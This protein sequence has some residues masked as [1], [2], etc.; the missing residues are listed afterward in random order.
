MKR[1]ETEDKYKWKLEDIFESEEDWEKAYRKTSERLT[2]YRFF[3]N[4]TISSAENLHKCLALDEE[5]SLS[6]EQL[7]VY[8]AMRRDQDTSNT[9]YQSLIGRAESLSV[10]VSSA[11]SFIVP[12][13]LSL[14]M[15]DFDKYCNEVAELSHYKMMF[16][17]IIK[18]AP[19]ILTSEQEEILSQMGAIASA[20]SGIFNM[21][22]N[23]DLKFPKIADENGELVELTKS[24][25]AEF[26]ES[27]NRNSRE[28]AYKTLYS[29]YAKQRNTIAATLYANIK[30]NVFYAKVRKHPSALEK[31][32]FADNV[33]LEVY[34][35]LIKTVKKNLDPMDKYLEL[36]QDMLGLKNLHAYD[37]S[38]PLVPESNVKITYEEA[39]ET[40]KRGL[41]ILG[42]DYV[43]KLEEAR[44]EGWIDVYENEGKRG[45]A[46]SW[47]AYGSHPYV[48]LNHKDNL[49]SMFTLAHEMG[50]AMHS[51][52]SD[53][54]N[55][56]L[57]AG[58]TIFVAEVASTVNEVLL[59]N[60]LLKESKD[61][62]TKKYLLNYFLEQFRGTIYRQTMFAEFEMITHAAVENGE[63]LTVD[64]F[65]EIY[66]GLSKEYY[67]DML[68][69]D[70][71]VKTEWLR[72]PHFYNA[73]YVYKYATGF[74]AAISIA[75]SILEEGDP[76]V[77]R[78]L[79]FLKSG[80]TDYPIELL[81]I[82]GVDMSTAK[83]IE[84]ALQYFTDLVDELSD[85]HKS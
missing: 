37:I 80:G 77:E 6:I 76:A 13:L 35:N 53:E 39:Y 47:G 38:T 74:S 81:K 57:Y 5:I 61:N 59:M 60:H 62:E 8:A 56:Y 69:Q 55:P 12:E 20:P 16:E 46:Y 66:G 65:D 82:A 14:S 33:P 79:R 41:S 18:N 43:R 3:E 28:N 32:L 7:Y 22:N 58:Y 36:K 34:K 63:T 83:P 42:N 24:N 4:N 51:Y 23:A 73:F 67:G 17:E 1:D 10:E 45:G 26:M 85:I 50:H 70:A 78:Y 29:T 19:H 71:E 48:L 72:I 15:S 68:V 31:S 2:D 84:E 49:N 9:H 44:Q 30:K 27:S 40:M 75:K 54:A 25:Y 11:S 52:Y 64:R 21:L